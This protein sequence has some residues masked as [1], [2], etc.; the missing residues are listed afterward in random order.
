MIRAKRAN[1]FGITEYFH[2]SVIS[3]ICCLVVVLKERN[4]SM[5]GILIL[6]TLKR[7]EEQAH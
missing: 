4:M 1:I 7:H 6:I 5:L 3:V 2:S